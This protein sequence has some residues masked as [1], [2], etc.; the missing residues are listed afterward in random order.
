MI[1]RFGRT[2]NYLRVSVTDRCNLRCRYC[3]PPEGVPPL[4]HRDILSFEEIRDVVATAASMGVSKVR[5][6]GGEPLVRRGVVDLV[7]MLAAVAGIDDLAM[8]T[9]GTLLAGHAA[10][11]KAAGLMRVNVSLDCVEPR[12]YARITRGGRAADAIAGIDAAAAAGLTPVKLNCVVAESSDEP[13]ARDVAAFAAARGL[14]VRFIHRMDLPAGR[15]TTVEGGT[16]GDCASCNRLR[17]TSDARIRPCL[18]S[19][20]SFSVRELGVREALETSLAEKP[21]AGTRCTGAAMPRIGG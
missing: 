10:A 9:N 5:L 20:L 2:I 21:A 4:R 11:L 12:R 19:D 6:T 18:F 13:D 15:F 1:D 7:G 17:L 14:E 8:S 16:G 3:M